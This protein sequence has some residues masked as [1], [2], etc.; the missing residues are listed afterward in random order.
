[1]KSEM[2]KRNSQASRKARSKRLARKRLQDAALKMAILGVVG[3]L[4][5]TLLKGNMLA[6][7]FAQL[8]PLAFLSLLAGCFLYWF[9]ANEKPKTKERLS[10]AL[11][12]DPRQQTE[13]LLV[14][15][16][17]APA[18]AEAAPA[19]RI[20]LP[21]LPE[22]TVAELARA[23][24]VSQLSEADASRAA[25]SSEVFE[26]IEWRRFEAVVERLMQYGGFVTKSQSHGADGGVDVWL[27]AS[28]NPQQLVGL[29]Q[30]KHQ[31]SKVGV[32]KV[33]AL[34]GVMAAHGVERGPFATTSTFTP[35]AE[36]FARENGIQLLDGRALLKLIKLCTLEQQEALRQVAMEGDYWRPTCASCGT[37]MVERTAR[38]SGVK[39]WGCK[40][41][42]KCKN[43]LPMRDA[44]IRS[45]LSGAN[46]RL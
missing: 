14:A 19:Q 17:Q 22:R 28:E 7:V 8:Q 44:G 25:W 40:S 20:V 16:K 23:Q 24:S 45:A 42:P 33:R 10:T 46:W 32:E 15:E 3:L 2:Q 9:F 5:P 31:R 21:E 35:D 1:M 6:P 38:G 41:Y 13:S 4:L 26:V 43:R 37:K 36:K 29:T 30:C 12:P 27:Y 39:F 11:E 34:R 18:K